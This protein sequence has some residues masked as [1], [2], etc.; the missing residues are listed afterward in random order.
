MNI[1]KYWILPNTD[2]KKKPIQVIIFPVVA[3]LASLLS[4]MGPLPVARCYHSFYHAIAC[5]TSLDASGTDLIAPGPH[6]KKE[7]IAR[8][9]GGITANHRAI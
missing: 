7:S 2:N 3:L 1:A 6:P 9:R 8:A 5:D 4:P